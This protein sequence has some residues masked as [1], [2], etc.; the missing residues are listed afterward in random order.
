MV[1]CT[2]SE[3]KVLP[4][5]YS[6]IYPSREIKKPNFTSLFYCEFITLNFSAEIVYF[7]DL[8]VSMAY[9]INIAMNVVIGDF[10]EQM[11]IYKLNL[12]FDLLYLPLYSNEDRGRDTIRLYKYRKVIDCLSEHSCF[13]C[14]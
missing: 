12:F 6:G 11:W 7:C 4:G 5:S 8:I 10:A 9:T 2:I 13:S 14:Y 3:G 1:V